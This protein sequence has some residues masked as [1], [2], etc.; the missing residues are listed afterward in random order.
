MAIRKNPGKLLLTGGQGDFAIT[1]ITWMGFSRRGIKKKSLFLCR[2]LHSIVFLP[3]ST[4]YFLASWAWARF[5]AKLHTAFACGMWHGAHP[6]P[7]AFVKGLSLSYHSRL[8]A[9]VVGYLPWPSM[10]KGVSIRIV[11]W[12]IPYGCSIEAQCIPK[13]L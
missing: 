9:V 2:L 13:C 5:R 11:M 12:F 1:I 6:P 3:S 4:I 8:S 10:A 7:S